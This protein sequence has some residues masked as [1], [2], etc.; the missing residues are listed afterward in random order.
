LII[1][2]LSIDPRRVL[3]STVTYE[4]G[5]WI[6]AVK[7]QVGDGLMELSDDFDSEACALNWQEQ[8]DGHCY[9]GELADAISTKDVDDGDIDDLTITD[10]L[11]NC[12]I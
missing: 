8:L 12:C 6:L 11:M 5:K 9:K 1:G 3:A 4:R 10:A 2:K 7:L